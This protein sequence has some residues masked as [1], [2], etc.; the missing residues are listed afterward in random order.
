MKYKVILEDK[1][2]PA[3]GVLTCVIEAS[4][5]AEALIKA[6]DR[7]PYYHA[8]YA[9]MILGELKHETEQ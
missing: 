1:Q 2:T 8:F 3:M 9:T 4:S 7:Y 5:M 6:E